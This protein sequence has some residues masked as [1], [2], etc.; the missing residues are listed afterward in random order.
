MNVTF[1]ATAHIRG[2]DSNETDAHTEVEPNPPE[3]IIEP[4]F[5]MYLDNFREDCPVPPAGN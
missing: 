4:L 2:Y 3:L 1:A 5:D